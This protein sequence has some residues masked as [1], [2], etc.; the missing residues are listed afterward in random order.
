MDKS[1]NEGK[2]RL[3]N[4]LSLVSIF[5]IVMVCIL[6]VESNTTICQYCNNDSLI[7]SVYEITENTAT[8][9]SNGTA[10]FTCKYC[11]RSF[12]ASTEPIAHDWEIVSDSSSCLQSGIKISCC[13]IC[14]ERK[15]EIAEK[16][17]DH[18]LD[19]TDYKLSDNYLY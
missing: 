12:K 14:E 1:K 4:I 18:L 5:F 10:T 16:A 2:Y 6:R 3:L 15:S 13:R 17:K 7:E 19:E 8:C 9:T 11:N